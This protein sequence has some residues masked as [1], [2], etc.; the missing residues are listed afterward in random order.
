MPETST[1]VDA[2]RRAMELETKGRKFY[3][4]AM[5]QTDD[6]TGKEMF[7]TLAED[8]ALHLRTISRQLEALSS[9]K[10]WIQDTGGKE[11]PSGLDKPLLPP[12]KAT[13]QR[14]I[15]GH[16]SDIEALHFALEFENDSYNLYAQAAK[17]VTDPAGK[18]MYEYLADFERGHFNLL[19]ANYE[20]L[21]NY[22]RWLG[23][24]AS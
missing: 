22:G 1:A 14:R 3:L 23:P 5:E 24:K 2:L 18:A 9:G 7:Q 21:A 6:P 10:G 12:D 16:A 17:E 11:R 19:M 15:S 20:Y 4:E 13:M 8:E